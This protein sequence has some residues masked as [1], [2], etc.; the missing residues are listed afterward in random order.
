M[1]EI[2]GNQTA[3]EKFRH[4]KKKKGKKQKKNNT[5]TFNFFLKKS[6]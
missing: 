3:L 6:F 1:L 4:F 2:P 5:K